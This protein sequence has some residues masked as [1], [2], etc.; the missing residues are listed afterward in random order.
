MN[1]VSP[2][3]PTSEHHCKQNLSTQV[4][5]FCFQLYQILLILIALLGLLRS[6]IRSIL[7]GKTGLMGVDGRV[8]SSTT[9]SQHHS[10]PEDLLP[11]LTCPLPDEPR[12]RR[13]FVTPISVPAGTRRQHPGAVTQ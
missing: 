11:P 7:A 2:A 1:H 9:V 5:T 8:N 10:A 6:H 3:T 4:N 12:Y 13:P